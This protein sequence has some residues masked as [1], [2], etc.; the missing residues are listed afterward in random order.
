MKRCVTGKI[1]ST[2]Y[3]A[4][5]VR[6]LPDTNGP[7]QVSEVP[8][9]AVVPQKWILR[10][11]ARGLVR[12]EASVGKSHNDSRSLIVATGSGESVRSA[13]RTNVAKLPLFPQKSSHLH[14]E[15]RKG[16]GNAVVRDSYGLTCIIDGSPNTFAAAGNYAEIDDSPSYPQCCA[17]LREAIEGVNDS[18][19][20]CTDTPPPIV[21]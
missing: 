4:T 7:S 16:I 15:G 14:T 6:T 9:F 18:R 20:R 19:L 2:Y 13:Q 12:C 5:I 10:G 1:R 21:E 11:N 17:K 8:H 3:V